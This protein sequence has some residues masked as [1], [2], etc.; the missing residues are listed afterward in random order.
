MDKEKIKQ[1]I[2]D[3]KREIIAASIATG[4]TLILVKRNIRMN[5]ISYNDANAYIR[6][7]YDPI[8]GDWLLPENKHKVLQLYP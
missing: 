5:Y 8:N 6:A 7:A 1:F 4:V 3:N 2:K